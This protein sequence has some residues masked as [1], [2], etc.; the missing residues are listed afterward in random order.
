M[1]GEGAL[2]DGWA[3]ALLGE[4]ADVQL[5]KMLDR[6]R[7]EG[8]SL[9]YL[10]NIS[11]RWSSIELDN[12]PE[13]PF[14]D[15]ELERF[16]IQDGDVLVCEGGEPGRAAVWRGGATDIKYQKALHRV[17]FAAQVE[18]DWLVHNLY[19]D[20]TRGGLARHF[21][22]TTIA[23][24]TRQAIRA[25]P[26]R[27]APV[28]EQARVLEA[29]E[30]YFT[31]LDDAVATLERVERNLKRYRA[32]VLKSAV[33][34]RLVPTEAELAKQEGDRG[35]EPADVL[36]ERILK[37]RRRRWEEAELAKME[38]KGEPPKNDKWKAK[39]KEPADPDTTNL[40]DLP[41]G[42]C[43][44]RVEDLA[45]SKARSIGAG[46]FGTIFKAHDF[47]EEGVP[48]IFLRHVKPDEY[49]TAKP[50]F[51]LQERWDDLFTEYSVYGAE[52]LITKLGEPPGDCAIYP[53]GIGPA[54]LTPDVMKLQ[55]DGRFA[56]GRYVMH[57]LNSALARKFAFGAAFGTTRLRLTL[58]IFRSMPVPVPPLAEQVRIVNE[59]D[60][61]LSI[62]HDARRTIKLNEAKAKR[63]RQSILKWAFE[64]KLADQ[65]S[66]DEPASVLLERIKAERETAKPQ[67]KARRRVGGKKT[68]LI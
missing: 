6:K 10:R 52:L 51:M 21:T 63:L 30:S 1:S 60:R 33:E 47:R 37:E 9:P 49:R 25:Y 11:V 67:K 48:I 12:L 66:D 38:A 32:S 62:E 42:W 41:E 46:P 59:I 40:P 5:G 23:H 54:M 28:A 45:E 14:K 53:Q 3:S 15:S 24:F 39:Y 16:G 27:L 58:P 2:P 7:T 20:S 26:V 55:L 61:R 29:I 56:V 13:M 50:K 64:G 31:R 22:G 34:G 19:F 44:I 68:A 65:D 18:P 4:I 8:T 43:W 17:R 35:Y 57:Y 36:L